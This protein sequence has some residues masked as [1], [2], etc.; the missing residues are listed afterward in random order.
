MGEKKFTPGP[1]KAECIGTSSAGPDGE[2]VY[3]VTN[4][5][6]RIAEHC[7][8]ADANLIAAAPDLFEMLKIARDCIAY[9]RRVH[10]DIQKGSGLP[11]E[12]LIDAALAK[13]GA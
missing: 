5:F 13:A 4:G 6:K 3:E 10:P 8:E 2:D 12:V 11:V 1:W 7:S 9:C